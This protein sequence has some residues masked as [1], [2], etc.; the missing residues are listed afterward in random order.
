MGVQDIF[1]DW[2]KFYKDV[3]NIDVN[4][5]SIQVPAHQQDFDRVLII[6]QGLTLNQA[7]QVCINNFSSWKYADDLD[8][9]I[10]KN[11]RNPTV[12]YAVRFR[13]RVEA[14]EELKNLSANDL[15]RQ[16]VKGITLLERLI[17]EL[18]YWKETSMHLDIVNWTLCTGSRY[19]DGCVPGVSWRD[20]R[21]CV[22][23]DFSAY[24]RG[25]L[26]A[27]SAVTL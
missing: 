19:A 26:R 1:A 6:A 16:G 7:F 12:A 21:L 9:A 2:Q 13:D 24:S 17:Y 23:W 3:F 15:A 10:T 20:V 8:K 11:D 14:D 27:R 22:N 5:S 18:K 25:L 4:L